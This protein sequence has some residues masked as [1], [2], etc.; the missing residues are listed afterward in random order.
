MNVNRKFKA[1]LQEKGS[2]YSYEVEWRTN[3]SYLLIKSNGN[4]LLRLYLDDILDIQLSID[5]TLIAYPLINQK[6]ERKMYSIHS[7]ELNAFETLLRMAWT[8]QTPRSFYSMLLEKFYAFKHIFHHRR[9]SS[10]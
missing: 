7:D 1:R 8:S 2:D 6:R 3:K 4:Q 10:S 5:L 9:Q